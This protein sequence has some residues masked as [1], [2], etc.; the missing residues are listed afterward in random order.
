M[1]EAAREPGTGELVRQA[2]EQI[3]RL[4]RDELA[5]AREEM[6][7]KSKRAGVGAGLLG[8]GGVVALFGVAALL[9]A[10]VLGLAEGLPAWLSA[11]IVAV[12]LF[13]VAGVLALA[14]RRQVER[15]VPPVPAEAARSVRADI[16]EVKGRAKR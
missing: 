3:S 1:S 13:A 8:A 7:R 15:G 12:A 6:V 9:A 11:L 4:V 14:G 2:A 10:A 16:D 5:L